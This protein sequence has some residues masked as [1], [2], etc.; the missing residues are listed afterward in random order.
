MRAI[1]LP[2]LLALCIPGAGLAGPNSSSE[3]VREAQ[4]DPFRSPILDSSRTSTTVYGAYTLEQLHLTA[5]ATSEEGRLGVLSGPDGFSAVVAPGSTMGSTRYTVKSVLDDRILIED[6]G[7]GFDGA[8]GQLQYF[9]L[10][11]ASVTEL[12]SPAVGP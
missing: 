1:T 5:I 10:L 7:P 9:L 6:A 8:E 4:R 11:D 12:P 2:L 3:T